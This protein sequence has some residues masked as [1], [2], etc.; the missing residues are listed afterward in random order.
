MAWILRTWSL[1]WSVFLALAAFA[2]TLRLVL[3]VPHDSKNSRAVLYWDPVE[4][5]RS[6]DVLHLCGI[7]LLVV[8]FWLVPMVSVA[9][10][11]R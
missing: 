11:I 5:L 4:L 2:L 7:N 6:D 3:D 1:P 9:V 10:S 8:C